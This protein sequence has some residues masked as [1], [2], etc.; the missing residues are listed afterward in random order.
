MRYLLAFLPAL[1][2]AGLMYGCIRMMMTGS[3]RSSSAETPELEARVQRQQS[4]WFE[5][6]CHG[7]KYNTA[8]EYK[9]GPAPRGMDRFKV[10][11]SQTG[12]VTVETV[13]LPETRR[14]RIVVSDDG[15]GI[16]DEDKE[17][18]FVPYFSTK[19]TG[20]GLG[21]PIVSEIVG[22]HGGT[23]RVEDNTP[24]G[25]RF[26]IEIPVTRAPAVVEA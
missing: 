2:C 19:V 4:Q 7:S 14:A 12:D 24:S 20:M 3:H 13:W 18:L 16:T 5:C 26:I 22:E 11:V 21:L 10:T 25:S 8:G 1:A 23:I 15:P 6:P 17:R 9:L